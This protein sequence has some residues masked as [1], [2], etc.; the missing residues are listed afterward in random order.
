VPRVLRKLVE[1]SEAAL[2]ACLLLVPVDAA[3]VAKGGSPRFL[4]RHSV[5]DA[6]GNL[7]LDVM[8]HLVVHRDIVRFAVTQQA[9]VTEQLPQ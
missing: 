6:V 5:C 4:E 3:K 2:V 8:P 9:S 7:A 1:H